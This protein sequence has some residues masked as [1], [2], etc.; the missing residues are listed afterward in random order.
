MEKQTNPAHTA[1]YGIK[2]NLDT[3]VYNDSRQIEALSGCTAYMF[4]NI[5]DTIATVNGM[6]VH[7]SLTPLTDLGDSRSISAHDGDIFVGRITIAFIQPL[8]ANP[9]LE[10]VQ[11]YYI[12]P[13]Y[14][15]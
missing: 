10:L 5:G 4:T 14:Q 2:Y 12:D 11:V 6:V 9:L 8:G 3:Q 15:N 13:T 1:K 7:P